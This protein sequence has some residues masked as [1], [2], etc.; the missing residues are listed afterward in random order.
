MP[1]SFSIKHSSAKPRHN[2]YAAGQIDTSYY[3]WKTMGNPSMQHI[4]SL[5]LSFSLLLLLRCVAS[6]LA[7]LIP[8]H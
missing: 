5:S 2:L 7:H 8:S 4:P 3:V 6:P 1:S